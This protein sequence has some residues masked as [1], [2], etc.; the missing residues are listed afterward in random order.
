MIAQ[1]P[2]T[3]AD[4]FARRFV[5]SASHLPANEALESGC[6]RHVER[7]CSCHERIIASTGNGCQWLCDFDVAQ[8]PGRVRSAAPRCAIASKIQRRRADHPQRSLDITASSPL[9]T[10]A[11]NPP[12]PYDVALRIS[13]QVIVPASSSS[14]RACTR[15]FPSAEDREQARRLH[16][17]AS[18]CISLIRFSR[19]R[20][21][22][23][24]LVDLC[25]RKVRSDFG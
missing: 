5:A 25:Q 21:E 8:L 4:D 14:R 19:I 24:S 17:L 11:H 13:A 12:A 16:E 20:R 3:F 10:T 7:R 2:Q 1:H 22:G 6:Q 9:T 23:H 18:L 15:V